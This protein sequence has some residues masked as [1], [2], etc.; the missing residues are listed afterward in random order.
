MINKHKGGHLIKLI[1]GIEC[2]V[3][4]S[5]T[6]E[7]KLVSI[8]I[9]VYNKMSFLK[10]S[11]ESVVNQTLGMDKIEVIIVDDLSTDDSKIIINNFV[12]RYPEIIFVEMQKNTGSPATPRNI[13]TEISTGRYIAY[14]DADDWLAPKAME[15]L[16]TVLEETGD[17]Y[18]VGKTIEVSNKKQSVIA[19][20]ESYCDR[21]SLN[22]SD[23]PKVF[24]H[25][26]PRSKLVRASV[27]KENHIEFPNMKYAE[28]KQFF[29]DVVLNSKKMSTIT[30]VTYYLNRM[31]DNDASLIKQTSIFE[32][33]AT[34]IEVL[35]YVLKKN[36]STELQKP[37]LVRLVE[38]DSIIRFF[39]N[40]R[41][42]QSEKREEFF[43]MYKQVLVLLYDLSYDISDYFESEESKIAHRL[44]KDESYEKLVSF[45]DWTLQINKNSYIK[46]NNVYE[47]ID[48]EIGIAKE[49]KVPLRA[50]YEESYIEN[51]NLYMLISVYGE[52]AQQIN[53]IELQ[54]EEKGNSNISIVISNNKIKINV[55]EIEKKVD[56]SEYTL[57][58]IYDG[59][60][61]IAINA[62]KPK[63]VNE[64]NVT[65]SQ[66]ISFDFRTKESIFELKRMAFLKAYHT[67]NVQLVKIIKP[68]FIY[69]E[70]IF[71]K[72][73]RLSMLHAGDL[74]AIADICFT[75]RG[76][77]RLKT[78]DGNFLT[79]IKTH[80]KPV[81]DNELPHKITVKK[82]C[83]LYENVNFVKEERR[84]FQKIGSQLEVIALIKDK[85][86]RTRYKTKNGLFITAHFDFV[87]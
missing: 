24:Q 21:R 45:I 7:D 18:V 77:P 1:K 15:L 20:F 83:F 85:N 46:D 81:M 54:N 11:L 64:I 29:L 65:K 2:T 86:G 5:T 57:R 70:M 35:K 61:R 3:N 31:D 36:I 80:S 82:E 42:L 75:N 6:S 84:D 9:P 52:K 55:S 40:Q 56:Q 58:I 72:N 66:N 22:P 50:Y 41:F 87:E 12:E 28:D 78:Q 53:S 67:E 38:E 74:I 19:N 51:D 37:L 59:F 34:N 49:I 79:A 23:V 76:I 48:A 60:K 68:C 32:K 30:D 43:K 4:H 47:I 26:G 73:D 63:V 27:I 25:L 39:M 10:K 13:G 14:M 17:D 71:E 33:T 69:K 62:L 8:I 16:V 44:L